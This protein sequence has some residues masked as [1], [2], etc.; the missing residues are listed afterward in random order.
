MSFF[1][2]INI[3]R[4]DFAKKQLLDPALSQKSVVEV[5]IDS[6]FNSRSAFYSAFKKHVGK[7]PLQYKKL[8]KNALSAN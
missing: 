6:A 3:Q 5:A 2:F 8:H 4:I 7:T 1:D